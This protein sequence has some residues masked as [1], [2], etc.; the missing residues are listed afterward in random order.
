MLA[1]TADIICTAL[2]K[3]GKA[4]TSSL[5]FKPNQKYRDTLKVCTF[6]LRYYTDTATKALKV[7]KA[8]AAKAAAVAEK[9]NKKTKHQTSDS[10]EGEVGSC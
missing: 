7:K 4:S 9:K 3:V 1:E 2:T 6:F 8:N 10:D 5:G